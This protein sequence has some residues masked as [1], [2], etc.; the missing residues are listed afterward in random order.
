MLAS[1]AA[2][3][4]GYA[5]NQQACQQDVR[6]TASSV[7]LTTIRLAT[8]S[9]P[10]RVGT[11]WLDVDEEGSWEGMDKSV[12]GEGFVSFGH[13]GNNGFVLG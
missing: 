2:A 4:V 3:G 9:H 11:R 12:D 1:S 6:S 5:T 13:S 7:F 10:V 8:R